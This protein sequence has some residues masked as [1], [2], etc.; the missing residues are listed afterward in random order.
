MSA[1]S[2]TGEPPATTRLE[3]PDGQQSSAVDGAAAATPSTAPAGRVFA[4]LAVLSL[5]ALWLQHHI[6][7]EFKDLGVVALAGAVWGGIGEL[8]DLL[9]EESGV[10]KFTETVFRAPLRQ[11]LFFLARPVPLYIGTG[12][13]A[14][15]MVTI[16]SVTVR[17]EVPGEQSAVSLSS[18]DETG[19]PRKS[20]M[21][22]DQPVVRFRPVLTS[23]FGRLYRVDAEGYVPAQLTV[24]PFVGRE[25]LLG[26]DLVTSPSVLFRPFAEG[27]V[28]LRDGGVFSVKRVVGGKEEQLVTDSDSG[29]AAA[30]LIGRPKPVSD[31]MLVFWNLEATA[32]RA[33]DAIKA[34]LLLLWR[35]PKQLAM[36]GELSPRDCLVGEIRL[37]NRLRARGVVSLAGSSFVDVLMQ[38]VDSQP[39]KVPSC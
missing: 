2:T 39:A 14:L 24:F 22:P 10:R 20:T 9:G 21:N 18:L 1:R 33:P 19:V 3:P 7:F 32:S 25:V 15:A 16:S 6:G 30:F 5:G 38:D 31:A 8:A 23:P 12:L 28:A 29:S 36:R 35:T 27:I 17:S 26:R 37:H 34:Q 11:L 4:V 13:L